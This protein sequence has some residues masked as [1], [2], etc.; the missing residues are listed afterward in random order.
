MSTTAG[1]TSFTIALVSS[2]VL[3]LGVTGATEGNGSPADPGTVGVVML[4][5]C[6]VGDALLR[7]STARAT[8][9]PASSATAAMIATRTR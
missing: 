1:S 9:A 8:P 4:V 7:D 2:V 6:D 3:L 5:L